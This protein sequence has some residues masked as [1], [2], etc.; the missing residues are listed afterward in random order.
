MTIN[1]L[2]KKERKLFLRMGDVTQKEAK[3]L[4]QEL[5]KQCGNVRYE[6]D[7]AWIN[8]AVIRWESYLKSQYGELYL[9]PLRTPKRSLTRQIKEKQK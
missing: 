4:L 6:E 3:E 8:E 9:T 5:G 1:S 7:Y 2:R